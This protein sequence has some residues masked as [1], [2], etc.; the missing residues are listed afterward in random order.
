MMM[1]NRCLKTE[2]SSRIVEK[3]K[4]EQKIV[5]LLLSSFSFIWENHFQKW[6]IN[7]KSI[8]VCIEDDDGKQMLKNWKFIKNCWEEKNRAKDCATATF[9]IQF[10]SGK[11]L[12][13]MNHQRVREGNR[14]YT[15]NIPWT[16]SIPKLTTVGMLK[17]IMT[18]GQ[19]VETS[20]RYNWYSICLPGSNS[21]SQ[22]F[23]WILLV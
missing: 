18:V 8:T 15:F 13:E 10:H 6:T 3:K 12:S 23:L 14:V 16:L 4:T 2:N 17:Y 11:P 7:V 20:R 19:R 9:V 1:E 22:S 5:L 21:R